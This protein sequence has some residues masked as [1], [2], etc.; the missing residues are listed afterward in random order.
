M[1]KTLTCV[2]C[3]GHL[4]IK[5]ILNYKIIVETFN[6]ENDNIIYQKIIF[7]L[8]DFNL[9]INDYKIINKKNLDT[10]YLLNHEYVNYKNNI[11]QQINYLGQQKILEKEYITI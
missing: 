8:N 6:L 4:I 1:R 3:F 7:E 2:Y 10:I 9:S 5:H 11:N